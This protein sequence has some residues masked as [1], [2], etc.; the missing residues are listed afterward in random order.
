MDSKWVSRWWFERFV[1]FTPIWSIRGPRPQVK[2]EIRDMPSIL[3]LERQFRMAKPHKAMGLDRI[4]PELLRHAPRQMAYHLWPWFLKQAFTISEC[5]Q[6]KGG[7][8][9]AVFKRK[10]NMAECSNHRALLVSSSLSKAF[11]NTFRRRTIPFVQEAGGAMQVSSQS[12]PSV[13]TAAHVVRAHMNMTRRVGLS[14]FAL[15]L[16][17]QQAFYQVIRQFAFASLQATRKK[18]PLFGEDFQFD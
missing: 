6:H 16:D 3:E 8:L 10:G 7:Q 18:E 1:V 14:A 15:F 17:I 4:P 2:F 9:V 12:R 5:V 13:L 11:H